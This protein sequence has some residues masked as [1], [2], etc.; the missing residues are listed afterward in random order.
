M[1]VFGTYVF[2]VLISLLGLEAICGAVYTM[3]YGRHRSPWF[4]GP[5]LQTLKYGDDYDFDT[6]SIWTNREMPRTEGLFAKEKISLPPKGND[7]WVF[8]LGGST[9]AN[10]RKPLGDR[11]SD[12]I[13]RNLGQIG[14]KKVRV[15]NFGVPSFV[16]FNE[17]ALLSGKLLAFRPD[18]V[19]AYDGVNDAHYGAL[20]KDGIWR[21]NFTS[22]AES[23][24]ERFVADINLQQGVRQRFL[25]L[26]RAVSYTMFLVDEVTVGAE[27]RQ[28]RDR[29]KM[30]PGE[31]STWYSSTREKACQA[32]V[33]G[34][35]PY[36]FLADQAS[37]R[38]EAAFAYAQNIIAMQ[39]A[40]ESVG[41][42]FVHV[43]QPT[44]LNK[45][46]IYPCEDFSFRWNG[47]AHNYFRRELS[48][49]FEMFGEAVT[50]AAKKQKGG[51]YIDLS[52]ATD[53]IDEYLYD[54]W[55]HENP[56]GRLFDIVG[57]M[58]ATDILK[59]LPQ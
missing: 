28:I 52:H 4:G 23:Y 46:K 8:L 15:F 30:T 11:L 13:E 27:I 7:Y 33:D 47:K 31:Y 32:S 1:R 14:G 57:K 2:I 34:A 9:V 19:I 21:Q 44:A 38:P 16:T 35:A 18:M 17:L 41:A 10:V 42:K 55:H 25:S 43:L 20:T 58:V 45:A 48:R 59:N 29:D 36:P 40:T 6:A 56:T 54:D 51:I 39:A 12:H 3:N 24:R 5:P 22:L 26:L 49:Q 37:A 50:Q 53:D